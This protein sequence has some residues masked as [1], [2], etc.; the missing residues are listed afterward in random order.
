MPRLSVVILVGFLLC[1]GL[2]LLTG[3]GTLDAMS[4][5]KPPA[6]QTQ[7][8]T[9]TPDSPPVAASTITFTQV[10]PIFS[11][12]C[13]YCHSGETAPEGL[14]LDSYASTLESRERAWIV[15]GN[16]AASELV[17]RIR[18][19]ARPSM[20]FNQP[21]LPAEQITLIETWIL[22]GARAADGTPAPLPVGARVRLH[23]TLNDFWIVDGLPLIVDGGTRIDDGPRPGSYVQVR[24]NIQADGSVRVE[25]IRSR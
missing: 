8:S 9:T 4:R 16:P 18:G 13:A 7:Q 15:P 19:Q 24:G 5:S 11:G 25:R 23:G 10:E 6:A 22:Q 17:R 20:P 14:R 3:T 12:N 1:A 21:Q 2:F